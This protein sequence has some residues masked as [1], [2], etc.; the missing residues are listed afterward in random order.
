MK[1]RTCSHGADNNESKCA[2]N[3]GAV[4]NTFKIGGKFEK[5]FPTV[6][7]Q[8][9]SFPAKKKGCLFQTIVRRSFTAI[10]FMAMPTMSIC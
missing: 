8:K 5:E 2:T 3:E 7:F 10:I 1:R 6:T 9:K 4:D